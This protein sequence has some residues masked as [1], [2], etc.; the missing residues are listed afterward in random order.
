MSVV[1]P[2]CALG[3][4]CPQGSSVENPCAAGSFCTTAASQT[5]C[6]AGTY[7]P[8]GST[9]GI[10]CPA[11]RYCP[12]GASGTTACTLGQYCG[13]TG[14]SAPPPC[15]AGSYC[16]NV[17]SQITC[18][19]G[20]YCLASSTNATLCP[21]GTYCVSAGIPRVRLAPTVRTQPAR[22]PAPPGTPAPLAPPPPFRVPEASSARPMCL[23]R[24]PVMGG[25]PW[26]KRLDGLRHRL[27][28][29][30]QCKLPDSVCTWHVLPECTTVLLLPLCW[31]QLLPQCHQQNHMPGWDVLPCWVH[32]L[33]HVHLGVHL[34]KQLL[35]SSPLRSGQLLFHSFFTADDMPRRDVLPRGLHRGH[36]LCKGLLLSQRHSSPSPLRSRQLLYH[37]RHANHLHDRSILP[38]KQHSTHT[39]PERELLCYNRTVS[40]PALRDW[41]LLPKRYHA[42]RVSAY[43]LL[44]CRD[45]L[46]V[47]MSSWVLLSHS[48]PEDSLPRGGP[49]G[50]NQTTTRTLGRGE[51]QPR[52]GP[53]NN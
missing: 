17:T 38:S 18:P 46:T 34:P 39:V 36:F 10:N 37:V 11:G 41:Q 42:I 21:S 33:H 15:A 43:N 16:P 44:S 1:R 35:C 32:Q 6:N 22:S 30:T 31:G 40:S 19:K 25:A 4:Y 24:C 3:K 50:G 45:S 53:T 8:A 26:I 13:T 9:A 12:Q 23:H 47:L 27:L 7:C 20:T 51:G 52:P 2:A 14:L 29:P 5:I 49:T 48:L 28:L